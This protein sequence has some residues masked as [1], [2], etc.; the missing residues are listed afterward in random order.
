LTHFLK[1]LVDLKQLIFVFFALLAGLKLLNGLLEVGSVVL[2]LSVL[3]LLFAF[4][5]LNTVERVT[6]GD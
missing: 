6:V 1:F 4:Q 3:T 5:Q 2:Q